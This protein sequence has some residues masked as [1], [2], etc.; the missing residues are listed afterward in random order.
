MGETALRSDARRNRDRILAAARDVF[1]EHGLDAPMN[2]IARQAGVGIATVFRRFPTRDDLVA[3]V[4]VDRMCA[5]AAAI[6]VALEDPDP[7]HGFCEYVRT[8][9][10]M[11]VGDRGF[12]D[13]ITQSFPT[14]PGLERERD[15]AFRRF[16]RLVRRAQR[17]GGLREDFVPEDLPML[18]MANAGV[19]A[20]TAAAAPETS[21]RVVAY[22]LQA[23]AAASQ[24]PLPAPPTPQRM[25]AA[26]VR[27][28][29]AR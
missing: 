8:I 18:L 4:F 5:Y 26:M 23:F 22:L 25:Y 3:A 28:Q 17:A 12:T 6:D 11:Q 9:C 1:A 19:V 15:E 14:A 16:T 24:A 2:E 21:E 10:A 27:A 29:T 7:W 13:V 20:V